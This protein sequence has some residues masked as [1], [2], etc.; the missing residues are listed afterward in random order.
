MEM[1]VK[2]AVPYPE[3]LDAGQS[4][5]VEVVRHREP[6]TDQLEALW[7]SLPGRPHHTPFQSTGFI[8]AFRTH[9]ASAE[10][11][12]FS[13]LAASFGK[14]MAPDM[15]LPLVTFRRG[16]FRIA[17]MPDMGLADQNAPV[18]SQRLTGDPQ[19]A[20]VLCSAL[21][22][23]VRGADLVDVAKI[24][25]LI[26]AVENPLSQMQE[27]VETQGTLVF[28]GEALAEAGSASSKSVYKEARTKFRKLQKAGV[29]LVEVTEPQERLSYLEMLLKQRADRFAALGREDSLRLH[30]RA[31]F[32]RELAGSDGM[33]NPLRILA[34]KKHDEVVATTVLMVHEGIANGV[35]ISMGDPSWHRMSPG[36]VLLVQAI[37]W[38]R[39][40]KI[41]SF[42][43]GT[44]LQSYKHRFGAQELTNRRLLL[45]LNLQ[46]RGYLAMMRLRNATRSVMDRYE[47]AAKKDL[48]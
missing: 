16:P 26:G 29:D 19:A 5:P 9:I 31:D 36:I 10:E 1:T 34:L 7:H 15:L 8:H 48:E 18:L 25:P 33:D 28:D 35:L 32:Y 22:Q 2:A 17:S 39:E 21:L 30:G 6:T 42:N 23:S 40:H 47:K 37:Q 46:G 4:G 3:T 41:S 27:T 43:F 13:V 11:M 44:G 20:R 14:S 12:R 24:S 45:P 38:A